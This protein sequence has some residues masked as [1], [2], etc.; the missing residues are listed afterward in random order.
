MEGGDFVYVGVM[1]L[2]WNHFTKCAEEMLGRRLQ[3][4]GGGCGAVSE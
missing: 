2:H 1:R 4:R 3:E